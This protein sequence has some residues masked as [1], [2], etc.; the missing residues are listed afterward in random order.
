MSITIHR[1]LPDTPGSWAR[2]EIFEDRVRAFLKEYLP[3]TN[4]SRAVH[5]LRMRW[6]DRTI[7]TGYY[8][9]CHEDG[10][11]FGHLVSYVAHNFGEPYLLFWQIQM[12]QSPF[13]LQAIREAG[14]LIR[15]WVKVYNNIL[16][17]AKR[18]ERL[19]RGESW[20][21]IDPEIYLRLFRAAGF[22][23]EAERHVFS[24]KLE[25]F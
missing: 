3:R 18:Q 5:D 12:D 14:E 15:K 2:Y 9:A 23:I 13:A 16:T 22:E 10:E 25:K 19:T 8:L 6:I 7:E 21:W 20:S 24:W 1:L 4:E 17:A 11:P